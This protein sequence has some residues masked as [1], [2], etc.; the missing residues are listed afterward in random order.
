MSGELLPQAKNSTAHSWNSNPGPLLV[1]SREG[2]FQENTTQFLCITGNL[3]NDHQL[4]CVALR[5]LILWS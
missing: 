1:T 4:F 2:D 5:S 3:I